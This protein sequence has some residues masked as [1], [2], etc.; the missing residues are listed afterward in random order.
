[1]N[2]KT[3]YYVEEVRTN[4]KRLLAK[5]MYKNKGGFDATSINKT[6]KPYVQNDQPLTSSNVKDNNRPNP[7]ATKT[8]IPNPNLN[9][10]KKNELYQHTI[11]DDPRNFN[12]KQRL[13]GIINRVGKSKNALK[14]SNKTIEEVKSIRDKLQDNGYDLKGLR[15]DG[16]FPD[17]IV[18]IHTTKA[19]YK[20]F[21]E[22]SFGNKKFGEGAMAHGIGAYTT[23]TNYTIAFCKKKVSKIF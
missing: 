5:T 9:V 23:L 22:D 11:A 15:N 21:N 3:T 20:D 6:P 8:I 12:I 4:E 13:V 14:Q 7:S 10:K 1:M 18:S 2:D 19:D 16:N 17:V